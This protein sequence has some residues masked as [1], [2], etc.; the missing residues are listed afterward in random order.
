MRIL[1]R[2]PQR[3]VA[4]ALVEFRGGRARLHRVRD[5]A[6]VD[7]VELGDVRGLGE[8][9]IDVGL[10][11]DFPVIDQIARSLG[12]NLGRALVECVRQVDV[13]RLHLVVH[14]DRLGGVLRLVDAVGDHHR[15]RVTDI[16]HGIECHHRMGR[17]LVRLAV[18]VLDHP[19]A[20]QAAHLRVGDI[21]AG[22]DLD[23]ARHCLG[24]CRVDLLDLRMSMRGTQEIRVGRPSE[25][26]IVDV[27]AR[28]GKEALVFPAEYPGA[29]SG[30]GGHGV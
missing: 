28:S 26:Q 20:D 13:G 15:H 5:Q 14:L 29:D 2:R 7:D 23:D 19:A 25:G 12:V 6:I 22:E 24:L 21:L 18:L 3:V 8:R 17:R 1:R 10:H 11:A 4:S 27:A 16:A 9:G 30:S